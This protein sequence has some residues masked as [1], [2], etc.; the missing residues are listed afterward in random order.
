MQLDCDVLI[1]GAGPAGLALAAALV[2]AGLSVTVLD[3]QD[4][5]ALAAPAEDGREIALTHSSVALLRTLGQWQRLAD[6]EIGT[7]RAAQ[8]VDGPLQQAAL[9]FTT[10]RNPD[11]RLG[12]IV[13]NHAL[14]RVGFEVAASLP[15][16]RIIDN[17]RVDQVTTTATHAE[18]SWGAASGT[19]QRLRARL[20][21]A[22]DSR[23]SQTR[24]ASVSSG[25][26]A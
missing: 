7:I 20:L 15:G 9:H 16:L 24:R 10:P 5:A 23:F 21:V 18:V 13:P 22:A 6:S 26:S 3:S 1:V 2:G 4:R 11:E 25:R 8:V 14:R 19:P 17:T 12:W